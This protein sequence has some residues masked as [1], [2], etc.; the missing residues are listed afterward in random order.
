MIYFHA[1]PYKTLRIGG[2]GLIVFIHIYSRCTYA[3]AEGFGWKQEFD[4]PVQAH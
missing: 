4:L 2:E 1:L 3:W